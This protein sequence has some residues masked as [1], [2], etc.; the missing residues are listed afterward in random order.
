MDAVGALSNL[1]PLIAGAV[2]LLALLVI[3]LLSRSPEDSAK[4]RIQ[5]EKARLIARGDLPLVEDRRRAA[6]PILSH[7][8]GHINPHSRD[9]DDINWQD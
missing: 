8:K 5:A 9:E 6:R 2:I 3:F 1:A 4:K 7:K